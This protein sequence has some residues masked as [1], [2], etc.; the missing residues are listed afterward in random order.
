MVI[1]LDGPVSCLAAFSSTDMGLVGGTAAGY[2][3][4]ARMRKW[5][6][7]SVSWPNLPTPKC[8]LLVGARPPV[9]VH[10]GPLELSRP[11]FRAGLQWRAMSD[12]INSMLNGSDLSARKRHR[13]RWFLA[14][15]ALLLLTDGVLLTALA[16]RRF[17]GERVDPAQGARF[18][19]KQVSKQVS[20]TDPRIASA[21]GILQRQGLTAAL[22]ALD[23]A[24]A[25]DST[26]L[27]G[28]HQLAHALG[29]Q[30]VAVHGGDAS[31][32]RECRADFASGCYHGVVEA[33]IQAR[34]KVEMAELERMCLGT[35]SIERPGPIYECIHGLGHGVL[36][37]SGFDL[38]MALHHCDALSASKFQSACHSG[39]F[40][41][42][43]SSALAA[44]NSG[45]APVHHDDHR[46]EQASHEMHGAHP[47]RQLSLDAKHPYG[48]CD[49]FDDPYAVSCWQF[50]GFL[51]LLHHRF[52][53]AEAFRTCDDAPNGQAG[54]C[55][56]SIGQQLTGL[57][58]RDDAWIV[59]QCSEGRPALAQ[60]CAGGAAMALDQM[61]WSGTRAA[62]L[63]AASPK[64]WKETCYR[65]AAATLTTL[66]SP[67]ERSALCARIEPA[68]TA[69][70][71][72]AAELLTSPSAS[73]RTGSPPTRSP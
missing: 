1:P 20:T 8:H 30:A 55:Y 46:A 24:A 38:G 59:R 10:R 45:A 9:Q 68:Y 41:E 40:M 64:E 31:V 28:A 58:Q 32:I 14:F 36:G 3:V 12:M 4:A 2:R 44:P 23:D 7:T 65:T 51:I 27:R 72:E 50:Q 29:R 43:I 54:R 22:D 18:D 5:R 21:F 49:G 17:A 60:R 57:L 53:P 66:A 61:D 34:G 47:G 39:A 19:W 33:F 71:R 13:G 11:G 35:G 63:C 37:A 25:K 52:N 42:A 62:R 48:P 6:K 69:A 26:I 73:P 56:E 67:T 16:A 70:C 15:V